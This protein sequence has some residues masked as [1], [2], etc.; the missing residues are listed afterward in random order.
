[1][2]NLSGRIFKTLLA[3]FRGHNIRCGKRVK[4]ELVNAEDRIGRD[5]SI[6]DNALISSAGGGAILIGERCEIGIGA[7]IQSYGGRI[8]IGHDCSINPYCVIY[9]HGGLK[10]G[11]SVR[12]ATHTVI[13][14]SNHNYDDLGMP[15]RLQGLTLKGITIEDDVWIGAGAKILDGVTIGKGSVVA[16]G[17]V[18]IRNVPPFSVTAGV[19]N[20]I[21]KQRGKANP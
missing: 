6:G 8:V 17:T 3:P 5:T 20:R 9:G 18:V 2:S 7:L 4:L 14:P 21:I 13:V 12:I 1:M 16:A 11:N 19:P 15:I 10:I